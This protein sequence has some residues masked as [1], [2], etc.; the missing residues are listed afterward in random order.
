[1]HLEGVSDFAI[2]PGIDKHSVAVFVPER[3]VEDQ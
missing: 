2:T 3:K 1:L